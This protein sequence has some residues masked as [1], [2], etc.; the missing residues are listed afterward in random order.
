MKWELAQAPERAQVEAVARACGIESPLIAAVVARRLGGQSPEAYLAPAEAPL[1]PPEELPE[2]AQAVERIRLAIAR[3]EPISVFGDYDAD[4]I[5]G[6]TL[7]VKALKAAGAACVQPFFPDREREGY[8]LTV[9]A[10]TRCLQRHK[11]APTLLITVDCG[12]TCA[13]EVAWLADRKIEVVVTDHHTLPEVLPQAVAVVNPQRLPEGHPARGMCGCATAFTLVRELEAA[14]LPVH[15]E[16]YLDLVAVATIADVMALTGDNR[17]LVARGLALLASGRGNPGLSELLR[18]LRAPKATGAPTAEEVAFGMIPCINAAGRV[19]SQL[20]EHYRQGGAFRG[21]YDFESRLSPLHRVYRLLADGEAGRAF[22][23]DLMALNRLRKQAEAELHKVLAGCTPVSGEQ[24]MIVPCQE[25]YAGVAGIV[26]ARLMGRVGVP[27]AVVCQDGAG[28]AHGSMRSCGSWHAVEAL[29]TVEDLLVNYGRHAKAA[30]FVLKPGAYA[31]FCRRLPQA[32]AAGDATES[33]TYETDLTG[34]S[35][36]YV[37][38]CRELKRL[39]PMGHGNPKPIFRATFR[40]ES[41]RAIGKTKEHLAFQLAPVPS[42]E[43]L[44]AVWFGHGREVDCWP[45]GTEV[46]CYFTVSEDTFYTTP[47]PSLMIV[48]AVAC[49]C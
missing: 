4:G 14:G 11:P 45:A 6:T 37:D 12:I 30:G 42:G 40:V 3:G 7:L 20:L 38:L 15:A 22:A 46:L 35:A 13:A 24:V 10:L 21:L 8:G 43:P 19:G 33:A 27:V 18:A 9:E 44:K 29:R 39:E 17:T 41:C 23:K 47:R 36:L 5:T 34:E 1:S 2:M 49:K 31:E 26:A 48:E 16:A 25:L 28:N 32:F